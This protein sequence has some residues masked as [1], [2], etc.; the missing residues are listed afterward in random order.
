MTDTDSEIL[1]M[2]DNDGVRALAAARNS[3]NNDVAAELTKVS[4]GYG[5]RLR[6]DHPLAQTITALTR[7]LVETGFTL[8]DCATREQTGGVCLTPAS[9]EDGVIVTWTAHDSICMDGHRY[10]ENRDVHEVMND[11]LADILRSTGWKVEEFGQAGAHI[12]T[13]RVVEPDT[14]SES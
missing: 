10:G 6:L 11:A 2:L 13:G 12:V 1:A 4:D 8:H 9:R 5:E 7:T 14:A 3:L